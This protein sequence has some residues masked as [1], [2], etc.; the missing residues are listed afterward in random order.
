MSP[1]IIIISPG[2][3]SDESLIGGG[4]RYPMELG[5]A[6]AERADV[7]FVSFGPARRSLR[8]GRMMVELFPV[9]TWLAGNR[10]NPWS[11][12]FLKTLFS[13]DVVHV[14]QA[15]TLTGDF[16]CLLGALIGAR[17][18]ITHHGGGGEIAL[19]HNLPVQAV[20]RGIFAYSDFMAAA[21]PPSM[22]RGLVTI[23]GG[24]DQ[25]RFCPDA[26]V[27]RRR[28]VLFVGR[29]LP[30]KG[31]D[32]LVKAF[33]LWGREGWRLRLVGR[34]YDAA[35]VAELRELAAGLP[36]DFVHDADDEALLCEYR[37][38]RVTVLPSVHRDRSG[39]YTAVPEFM[40]FTLLESQSCGTPVICTDAGAMREFVADG[41]TG[42]VVHQNSP[43]ELASALDEVCDEARWP[44]LA[45]TARDWCSQF[46]W[47][48]VA[49]DHLAVY[50]SH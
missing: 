37:Q 29:L 19:S 41:I 30:H 7:T 8:A 48:R 2:Y 39:R 46:G 4:E 36:V 33:R 20:C 32:Y 16:A 13:A 45:G 1:R 22:H 6:L 47:S 21:L 35:Y 42:R 50:E 34:P 49:A 9:S 18:F 10:G 26:L 25:V 44:V 12:S 43:E 14:H 23:R 40:G 27:E 15:F 38:A 31:V 5:R 17:V 11:L 28:V 3:F 24:I